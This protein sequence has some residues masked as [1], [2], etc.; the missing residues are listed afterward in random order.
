[1]TSP[2]A[3]RSAFV[4][5][6]VAALLGSV[7]VW[8]LSG[9]LE[10]LVALAETDRVAALALFRSRALPALFAVVA[11]AVVS[12]AVLMRQGL[13]TVNAAQESADLRDGNGDRAHASARLVGW[14]MAAAGFIT[15]A[16]PLALISLVL[17]LLRRA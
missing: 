5:W 13:R 17:W 1:M 14:M 11:I 7:G 6:I 4:A 10:D 15:A 2:T 3:T 12:G 9:Y 16:V 8:W